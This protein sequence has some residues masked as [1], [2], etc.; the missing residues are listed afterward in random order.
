MFWKI[1]KKRRSKEDDINLMRA[2]CS[3]LSQKYSYLKNQ[4][5]EAIIIEVKLDKKD[6]FRENKFRE[7]KLDVDLLNKYENRNI[8]DFFIENIISRHKISN[9][10]I[11]IS[12][13]IADGLLMGYYVNIDDIE[14][15][16]LKYIDVNHIN[17]KY[18]DNDNPIIK[19]LNKEELSFIN[20]SDFYEVELDDIKY[21]HILDLED[22]DFIGIDD[23][24]NV[25]KIT[26]D[27]Y[28]IKLLSSDLLTILKSDSFSN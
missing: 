10:K 20:K 22:G 5:D 9:N 7:F 6:K 27:P 8:S 28:E 19:I 14:Q 1:F 23:K 13:Y 18:L 26:H 16:D 2:V 11:L 3:Q 15:I 21:Y 12:L 17:I 25:Y 24:K 4:I